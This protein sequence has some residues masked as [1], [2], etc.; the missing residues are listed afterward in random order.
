M[1]LESCLVVCEI[2][3]AE[4]LAGPLFFRKFGH[5]VPTFPHHFVAL[6]GDA[7]RG[8]RVAGYTHIHAHQGV[9]L[10]GGSCTDGRVIRRMSESERA[11]LGQAG[12]MLR[13]ILE[14]IFSRLQDST[15][16]FFAYSGNPLAISIAGCAGLLPTRHPN[17][18]ARWN[19]PLP[20]TRQQ[21][22]Q[23]MVESLGPF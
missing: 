21:E 8:Y 22:L 1:N 15:E 14:R 2:D 19:R 7:D 17:I 4:R 5:P 23:A 13:V 18:L 9:L 6:Y 11:A 12:G 3:Q 20:A 10:V 16:A